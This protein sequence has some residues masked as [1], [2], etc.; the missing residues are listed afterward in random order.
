MRSASAAVYTL[1]CGVPLLMTTLSCVGR[2]QC[3]TT[4][5]H[6]LMSACVN[7]MI[8]R[9]FSCSPSCYIVKMSN[10]KCRL[11]NLAL[12]DESNHEMAY[13]RSDDYAE[14]VN[15]SSDELSSLQRRQI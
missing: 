10:A 14:S 4:Q 9:I 8:S 3:P 12:D 1:L 11:Q 2:R 5:S 7:K 13:F 15:L 6:I